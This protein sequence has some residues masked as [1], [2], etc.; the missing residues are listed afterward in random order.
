[1]NNQDTNIE[2]SVLADLSTQNADAI[3][4]GP[5]HKNKRTIVLQSSATGVEGEVQQVT[6]LGSA[7]NHNEISAAD[8]VEEDAAETGRLTDLTIS[9]AQSDEIKGGM[10]LPAVQ[11]VREAAA[12]MQSGSS[13]MSAGKVSYSD[14]S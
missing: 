14:L 4:G 13:G 11:K 10:L 7:S 2:S 3:K 8:E 5:N 6:I 1:M 9:E 12:R